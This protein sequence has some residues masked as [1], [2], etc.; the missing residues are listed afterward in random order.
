VLGWTLWIWGQT[1]SLPG[2]AN[3][4]SPE[5]EIQTVHSAS[6]GGGGGGDSNEAATRPEASKSGSVTFMPSNDTVLDPGGHASTS[7]LPGTE[8]AKYVR[9][10]RP[11]EAAL[12]LSGGALIIMRCAA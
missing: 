4:V 8:S 3:R 2:T 1:M 10:P 12:R 11:K 7:S 5:E 9:I 6:E